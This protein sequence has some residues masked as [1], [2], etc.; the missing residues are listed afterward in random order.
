[1]DQPRTRVAPLTIATLILILP[2]LYVGSY[3]LLVM[4]TGIARQ[5]VAR[6]PLITPG[7]YFVQFTEIYLDH[8]RLGGSYAERVYFPLESVDR[9]LGPWSDAEFAVDH[10]YGQIV[11]D[12]KAKP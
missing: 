7:G 5:R 2:L 11:P 8:Y 10:S 1:M 3:L 6:Q 12:Y 4:P 9:R